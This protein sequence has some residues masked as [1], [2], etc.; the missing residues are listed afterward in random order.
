MMYFI[1]EFAHFENDS[2][3]DAA[4][5]QNTDIRIYASTVNGAGN[6]FYRKRH[7]KEYPV[8]VFDWRDDPRKDDAW[9]AK[10]KR[11]LEPHILAQEIDRDYH[12]SVQRTVIPA[13]HIRAAQLIIR[14][15]RQ[16]PSFGGGIGGA[17]VGA[18]G[19]G[20]TTFTARFGPFTDPTITWDEG[21]TTNAARL[22]YDAARKAGV[23]E[24]NFD[25]IGVGQGV[26]STLRRLE[27]EADIIVSPINVGLPGSE[28]VW[29]DGKRGKE[30]FANMKAEIWWIA[31]DRFAKTY[32]RLLWEQGDREKGVEHPLDEL[33]VLHPD[34]HELAA[35]LALPT[36]SSTHT[37]KIIMESK[38][39]L[40]RR[41]VASPDHAEAFVLT[42]APGAARMNE[43]EIEG[44]Y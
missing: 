14:Y 18:G 32:E 7:A 3:A 5:S 6:L 25:S 29:T 23:K 16:W 15:V 34:D 42:F 11:L 2:Q 12:A 28:R 41:G 35:E 40:R 1:D 19:S 38:Q 43:A 10:Q 4:L 8:F 27:S 33:V 39:A 9:Y 37:G 21:D 22:I 20:K 36:W 30:K 17:D 26:A 44:L 13:A 31:R 24:L